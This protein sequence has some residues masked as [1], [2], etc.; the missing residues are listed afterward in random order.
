[1]QTDNVHLSLLK[2]KRIQQNA[3]HAS[4]CIHA[5]MNSDRGRQAKRHAQLKSFYTN[6]SRVKE[7][8]QDAKIIIVCVYLFST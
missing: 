7:H 4:Q 5:T 1:M 3:V 2:I 8:M 6:A